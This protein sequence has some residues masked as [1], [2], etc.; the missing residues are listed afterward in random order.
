MVPGFKPSGE[1]LVRLILAT[2]HILYPDLE[3]EREMIRSTLESM[4]GHR[5]RTAES[6]GI[7]VRTLAMKIKAYSLADVGRELRPGTRQN[8][9][10]QAQ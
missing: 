5:A 6:L 3:V 7:S 2:L 10:V 4:G 9:P 1:G 8:L